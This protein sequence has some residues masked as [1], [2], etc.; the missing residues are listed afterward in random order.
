MPI[1]LS[2]NKVKLK[3]IT[4]RQSRVYFLIKFKLLYS[5]NKFRE[6]NFS[7]R[8]NDIIIIF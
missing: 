6:Y 8:L 4:F 3:D 7:G 2:K 1:L 5:I